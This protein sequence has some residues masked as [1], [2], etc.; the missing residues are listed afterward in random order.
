[1]DGAW[2]ARAR[3]RWRGA[4]LW[5]MF[6]ATAILDGV[7]ALTRPF[8]GDRQSFYG[9]LLA[10]LILNL[11]AVLFFSRPFGAA[12]RHRRR[13]LPVVIARNYGGTVAV[14]LISA[15][16]LAIGVGRHVAIVDRQHA[17]NDAVV[18]A[19]AFIGDRAPQ[20]FRV[21][22]THPDTFTIQAGEV[23]RVCVPSRYRP[24]Y[25]CVIVRPHRPLAQ[26]VTPAGSEPNWT[27]ALGTD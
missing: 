14:L 27:L 26:S 8:S 20:E 21:N 5:P 17:L 10:G 23:Y 13:D 16:L 4:W 15:V 11:L 19:V 24:R 2:L 7:I 3:W 1:M 22:A 9:G 25:Y 18:R 12:L 6:V